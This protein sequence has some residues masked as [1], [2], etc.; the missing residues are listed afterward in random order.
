MNQKWLHYF[1]GIAY[2]ASVM[3]KDSTR[4][5]A[6]LVGPNREIRLTGYNGPPRGVEDLPERRERP[7]KYLYASHA[8][9]N[10]IA[11]AA[12]NGISTEGCE[13]YVTHHPCAHCAKAIIQAGIRH[14]VYCE[15]FDEASA[16]SAEVGASRQMFN[17]A[18][19]LVTHVP[20]PVDQ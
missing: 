10:I 5:G 7:T 14:V 13:L 11:F 12:R 6:V 2:H 8:E 1:L 9:A 4:V 20:R 3:S 15:G 16:I 18:G 19:V 17:E